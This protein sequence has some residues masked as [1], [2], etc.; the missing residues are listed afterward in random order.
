MRVRFEADDNV[1]YD[2]KTNFGWTCD[3]PDDISMPAVRTNYVVIPGRSGEL[4]LTEIDGSIYYEDV[5]FTITAQ[6]LC[7]TSEQAFTAVRQIANLFNGQRLKVFLNED[8]YYYDARVNIRDFNKEGLLLLCEIDV[9]AFPFRL[10]SNPT[11]VS[12]TLS[13]TPK[14]VTLNNGTMQVVPTISSTDGALITY[15]GTS[16]AIGAGDNVLLPTFVLHS[17]NNVVSVTGTGTITF[18][19]TKGEF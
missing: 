11:V 16:Y 1:I 13:S 3:L 7:R 6:R 10:Q 9:K 19:Y 4:D 12:T 17:G 18:T 14:S 15:E 8:E 5:E 2:L